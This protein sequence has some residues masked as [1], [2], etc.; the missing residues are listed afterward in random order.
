MLWQGCFRWVWEGQCLCCLG[1]W[2][3]AVLRDHPT[4]IKRRF[5]SVLVVSALSPFFVWTWREFTGVRVSLTT[6]FLRLGLQRP[7][8]VN[9]YH[10]YHIDI[11]KH[12]Y[13]RSFVD[14]SSQ[15]FINVEVVH[16]S[17]S[18]SCPSNFPSHQPLQICELLF[19]FL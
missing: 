3:A 18:I 13:C 9:E 17:F 2:L 7:V 11:N 10:K 4:V 8:H 6:L 1:N 15:G 19:F 12:A 16:F 5:T 14:R